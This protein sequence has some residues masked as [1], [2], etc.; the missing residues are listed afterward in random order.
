MIADGSRPPVIQQ[1]VGSPVAAAL[2]IVAEG[3]PAVCV[4]WPR[5]PPPPPLNVLSTSLLSGVKAEQPRNVNRIGGG[6][7][8]VAWIIQHRE[9]ILECG[10]VKRPLFEPWAERR[11]VR[12]ELTDQMNQMNQMDH[13]IHF[14]CLNMYW[15]VFGSSTQ[16]ASPVMVVP[17]QPSVKLNKQTLHL[18]ALWQ[19]R[20]LI[21]SLFWDSW[22]RH[23]GATAL[24]ILKKSYFQKINYT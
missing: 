16:T 11:A 22:N 13:H 2:L 5:A 15:L 18:L 17:A 10:T 23:W 20:I 24:K 4:H 19:Q 21:Y 9:K 7:E 1:C 12:S 6:G 8:A 14:L 3:P